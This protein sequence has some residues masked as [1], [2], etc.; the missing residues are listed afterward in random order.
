[1]NSKSFLGLG[2]RIVLL[3]WLFLVRPPG[4]IG[5]MRAQEPKTCWPENLTPPDLAGI[6]NG[7]FGGV[8]QPAK[9]RSRGSGPRR[10][11][12]SVVPGYVILDLN[13]DG[14]PDL[15]VTAAYADE[16]TGDTR[17]RFNFGSV[18]AGSEAVGR[19]YMVA[20]GSPVGTAI[21]DQASVGQLFLLVVLG[22]SDDCWRT[23]DPEARFAIAN[24][25]NFE[26]I[27]ISRY[28]GRIEAA[29]AGDSGLLAPPKLKGD[30][31]LL[32]SEDGR[33]DK[34]LYWTG[35]WF[36]WYPFTR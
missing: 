36:N 12:K 22:T 25:I 17:I 14:R 10:I 24:A 19:K 31:L 35:A 4:G 13:G 30:A 27:K 6:V 20:A 32:E 34:L 7:A 18:G 9:E 16:A 15:V 3:G 29:T 23:S 28:K 11:T 33:D 2:T 5:S 21:S 26:N 8:F 1:M